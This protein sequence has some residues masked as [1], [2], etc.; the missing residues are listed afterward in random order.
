MGILPRAANFIKRLTVLQRWSFYWS[1]KEVSVLLKLQA[2]H[3]HP[4]LQLGKEE[5]WD[6]SQENDTDITVF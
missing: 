2:F 3:G 1:P 5:G 6:T 4:T